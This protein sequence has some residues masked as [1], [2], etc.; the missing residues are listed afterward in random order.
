MLQRLFARHASEDRIEDAVDHGKTMEERDA[1]RERSQ[2]ILERL[3][4]KQAAA[5]QEEI[6]AR[7]AARE[8]AERAAEEAKATPPAVETPSA[9]AAETAETGTSAAEAPAEVTENVPAPASETPT[10][11]GEAV[12]QDFDAP[13]TA[14]DDAVRGTADPAS[15]TNAADHSGYFS[16]DAPLR[17]DAGDFLEP[18]YEAPRMDPPAGDEELHAEMP[19]DPARFEPAADPQA[20]RAVPD[21]HDD[22]EAME[23]IR[24]KAEEAKA[25]IAARLQQIEAEEHEEETET[26]PSN[27]RIDL[28]EDTPPVSPDDSSE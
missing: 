5:R 21:I 23:R 1:L 15:D 10:V 17:G 19:A 27:G 25:R 6:E 7:R 16:D 28:G 12:Q 4:R 22:P 20:E 26:A 8:A 14:H 2:L 3:S 13:E 9:T 11:A 18:R 24:K